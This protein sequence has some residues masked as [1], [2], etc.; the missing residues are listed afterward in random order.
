[1]TNHPQ[2]ER[3][4]VAVV[5][6]IHICLCLHTAF[7]KTI[8]HDEIW[9][10]PIGLANLKLADFSVERLNPPLTRMWAAL[11][12]Y[13]SGVDVEVA[14]D[15]TSISDE[16]VRSVNWKRWYFVGRVF[17][18]LF[19][20]A[21][22]VIVY[23]WTKELF[24]TCGAALSLLLYCTCPN[25]I[26]HS[27]LVTPDAGL[28]CGFVATLYF[29]QKCAQH[30]SWKWTFILGTVLGLTLCTKFTAVIIFPLILFPL[31]ILK[32]PERTYVSLSLHYIIASAV[33]LFVLNATMLFHGTLLWFSDYQFQSETLQSLQT[34]PV[35]ASLP[36]PFPKDY[37]LGVD[38]QR[39]VMSQAH[40]CF[41]DRAWSFD[42]FR[43]YFYKAI[44]YKSPLFTLVMFACALPLCFIKRNE[45]R[46][47][48]PLLALGIPGLLLVLIANQ[49]AVQL[50]IRYVLPTLVLMMILAGRTGAVLESVSKKLKWSLTFMGCLFPCLPLLNHP[51]H[52]AYFNEYAGGVNNGQQHLI[53]SNLDWGQ[54]LYL[55]KQ[56]IDEHDLDQVS[57]AYFGTFPPDLLNINYDLP[58]SFEP[59]PGW[60]FISVNYLVGRPHTLNRSD[61]TRHSTE[62][63]EYSQ[64]LHFKPVATL[65]HSIYVFHLHEEDVQAWRSQYPK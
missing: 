63:G 24:G 21:T 55:V 30:T 14:G 44:L 60:H 64:F 59:T 42:G 25:V 38:I 28:M 15:E 10:L 12:L 40:P 20:V 49:T 56:Y 57:L 6:A 26:A 43:N 16:F 50:G 1:M 2:R 37:V 48:R 35:L 32:A 52:L 8:T 34:W 11:P 23:T 51:H 31:V 65:G 22:A 39:Y 27:S 46:C 33:G 5:I 18:I 36:V 9:H 17:N 58:K 3:T 47:F 13:V 4:L 29:A 45:Q 53:D 19:S 62:F 61:R 54:D 7:L 41:L